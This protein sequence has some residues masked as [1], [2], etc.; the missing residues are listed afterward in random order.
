MYY[1]HWKLLWRASFLLPTLTSYEQYMRT[2][3]PRSMKIWWFNRALCSLIHLSALRN[4][5]LKPWAN[6]HMLTLKV[7]KGRWRSNRNLLT[8]ACNC[9]RLVK[10]FQYIGI[11]YCFS[12]FGTI[13][14]I[15]RFQ[16]IGIFYCFS[17]FGT[18]LIILFFFRTDD[19]S[20]KS[21]KPHHIQPPNSTHIWTLIRRCA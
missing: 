11:F 6:Q 13:L 19:C 14:I 5:S 7:I 18:I 16:Y 9:S 10:R 21:P 4:L 15:K 3:W 17:N 2:L 12:N 20:R 8:V 1:L